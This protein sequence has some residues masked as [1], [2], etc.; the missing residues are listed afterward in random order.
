[1]RFL[2]KEIQIPE[3]RTVKL[4]HQSRCMQQSRYD[5]DESSWSMRCKFRH[6]VCE[7]VY[8]LILSIQNLLQYESVL[9][10]CD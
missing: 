5:N 7:K 1:M 3:E 10:S 9:L 4:V 6:G 8:M 2:R